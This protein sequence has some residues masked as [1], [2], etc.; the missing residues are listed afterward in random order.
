M[1]QKRNK[2]LMGPT[3]DEDAWDAGRLISR[4]RLRSFDITALQRFER[5]LMG[6]ILI[7]KLASWKG[8]AFLLFVAWRR[9]LA[10][11]SPMLAERCDTIRHPSKLTRGVLSGGSVRDSSGAQFWVLFGNFSKP[12]SAIFQIS[13]FGR[14]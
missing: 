8:K 6:S 4:A 2:G 11:I 5:Q 9:L 14:M 3:K 13:T 12:D 7:F 1:R 10:F